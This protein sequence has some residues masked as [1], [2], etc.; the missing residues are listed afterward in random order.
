MIK[1]FWSWLEPETK[2]TILI[3]APILILGFLAL[4]HIHPLVTIACVLMGIYGAVFFAVELS[5]EC[6]DK[7]KKRWNSFYSTKRKI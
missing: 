6:I 3:I 1:L 4:L 5:R 7:I 2:R